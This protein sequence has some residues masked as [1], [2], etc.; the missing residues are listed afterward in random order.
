MNYQVIG[1]VQ[2]LIAVTG[3]EHRAYT[4]FTASLGPWGSIWAPH[5]QNQTANINEPKSGLEMS[6][7]AAVAPWQAAFTHLPDPKT[8]CTDRPHVPLHLISF[9]LSNMWK[10]SCG[11]SCSC[12]FTSSENCLMPQRI[13][14]LSLS[15]WAV[16]SGRKTEGCGLAH[17][18]MHCFLVEELE[19]KQSLIPTLSRKAS[20]GC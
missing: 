8:L 6:L 10:S 17:G 18:H 20:L 2:V 16:S 9:S 4:C 14:N 1:H 13:V 11:E 19:L 5:C 3:R 7:C 12:C 15:L